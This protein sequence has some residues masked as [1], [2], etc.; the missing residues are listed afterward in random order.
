MLTHNEKAHTRAVRYRRLA[1]AETDPQR[2]Q[3]LQRIAEEAERGVL[4][5]PDWMTPRTY[6]KEPPK[7][8]QSTKSNG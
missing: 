5:T 1:L 8:D 7:A 6:M 2:A 3:L 4:V